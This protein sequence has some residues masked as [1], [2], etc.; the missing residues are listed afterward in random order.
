MDDVFKA[1]SA[2][3]RRELLDALRVRD[4]QTLSDLCSVLNMTRQAV[5]KHLIVLEEAN[6][7]TT[8]RRGREKIH[9]LNPEPINAIYER[10]INKYDADR[11]DAL[12]DLKSAL[13]EPIMKSQSFIYTTY[14]EAEP[15]LIWRALTDAAFTRR[16]WGMEFETD[17]KPGSRFTVLHTKSGVRVS[18]DQMIIKEYDPF[19]RL[20]YGWESYPSEL[21][22]TGNFDD[23]FS[24]RAATE[25]RST[26]TFDLAPTGTQ[27]K[28]TVTHSGFAPNSVVLPNI[29]EGWPW[30][31]AGLKSFIESGRWQAVE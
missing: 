3:S 6:L 26:A 7:V 1:L 22:A 17:W 9:Y 11:I 29:S 24:A 19:R 10:W 23:N 30:V 4:E 16:Y 31:M 14:I 5:S 12:F 18:D 28:L 21:T 20:S 25:P 2:P 27:T 13:E 15:E 8:L